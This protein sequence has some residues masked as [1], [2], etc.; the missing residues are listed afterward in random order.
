MANVPLKVAQ[1]LAR[2]STITVTMD[3]YT[4]LAVDAL[5]AALKR[6]PVITPDYRHAH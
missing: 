6:L 5:A 1:M 2:H 3:H 4:H